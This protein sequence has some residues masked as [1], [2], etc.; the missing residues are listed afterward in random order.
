MMQSENMEIPLAIMPMMLLK[1]FSDGRT[2]R[3]QLGSPVHARAGQD[4]EGERSDSEL[5]Q[6]SIVRLEN[7]THSPSLGTISKVLTAIVKRIYIGDLT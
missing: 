1:G 6:S 2:Y 7:G 3:K 5:P 4:R